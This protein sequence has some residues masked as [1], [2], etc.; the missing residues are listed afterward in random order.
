M[1]RHNK[2]GIVLWASVILVIACTN[3][4]NDSLQSVVWQTKCFLRFHSLPA[5]D[6]TG[7]GGVSPDAPFQGQIGR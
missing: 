3:F 7:E 4:V 5:Y 6:S 2:Y 1:L